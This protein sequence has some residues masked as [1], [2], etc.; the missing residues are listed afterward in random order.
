MGSSATSNV[1]I[2]VIGDVISKVR[3]EFIDNG[4]PGDGILDELQRVI[5]FPNFI[6]LSVSFQ[7]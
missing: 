2:N 6:S 4:G 5:N 1:Y 3:D 7:F